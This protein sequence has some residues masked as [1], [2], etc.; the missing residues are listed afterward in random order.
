[1]IKITKRPADFS[2]VT[3]SLKYKSQLYTLIPQCKGCGGVK[4]NIITAIFTS[5][6]NVKL[7]VT[8]LTMTTRLAV[9]Q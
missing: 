7:I 6:D 3:P 9:K 1:M 8:T 2:K 4:G 5:C